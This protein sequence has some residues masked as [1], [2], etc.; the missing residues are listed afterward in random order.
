MKKTLTTK[1]KIQQMGFTLVEMLVV[2]SLIGILAALA[3]VSFGSSQ[4][5]ARDSQR[6]S[7]LKQF[8]TTI[9][10]YASLNSG[11]YPV[12]TTTL[13]IDSSDSNFC[14]DELNLT[15]CPI[16]PKN[17][18]NLVYKYVSNATGTSF[19]LWTG[20]ENKEVFWVICSSGRNGESDIAPSSSTCPI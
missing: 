4:K 7:D 8:Q 12:Y 6:K 18:E 16:D 19:V 11:L 20:L 2:I 5:Q 13:Q 3:L 14:T 1:N 15:S 17:T 9:E 10:N